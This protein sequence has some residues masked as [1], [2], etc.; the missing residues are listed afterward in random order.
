[1][2]VSIQRSLSFR[3]S[4]L[5]SLP[6]TPSRTRRTFPMPTTHTPLPPKRIQ[7]RIRL[8]TRLRTEIS[9]LRT[10]PTSRRRLSSHLHRRHSHLIHRTPTPQP[11]PRTPPSPLAVSS[12][13]SGSEGSSVPFCGEGSSSGEFQTRIHARPERVF[14]G[15]VC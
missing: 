15:G 1:M 4:Q 7:R 8:R 9:S 13:A 10:S 14:G 6:R 5:Y 12:Q 2:M 3:I 11:K